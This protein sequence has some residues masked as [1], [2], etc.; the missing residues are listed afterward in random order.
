MNAPA[1]LT[2]VGEIVTIALELTSRAHAV[3]S[4]R[5]NGN[6]A[7]LCAAAE[8]EGALLAIDG[9]IT[10]LRALR[11]TVAT[12]QLQLEKCGGCVF[13]PLPQCDN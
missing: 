13:K 11:A 2:K 10:A 6:A 5:C 4:M 1:L 3:A 9:A 8:F 7:G 12:S